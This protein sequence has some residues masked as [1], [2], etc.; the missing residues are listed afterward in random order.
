MPAFKNFAP[1]L[2]ILVLACSNSSAF[3]PSFQSQPS[4]R[5][6]SSYLNIASSDE[7]VDAKIPYQVARGDGSTGGGG[8]P[9][10][11]KQLDAD[12]QGLVRPKVNDLFKL[13]K[14]EENFHSH[15]SPSVGAA[16]T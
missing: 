10:P 8:L 14:A 4:F 1:M 16:S 9:M 11:N 12:D 7:T 13:V 2:A 3:K 15:K 5:M 6:G